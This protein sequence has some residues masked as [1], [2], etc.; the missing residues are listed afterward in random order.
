MLAVTLGTFMV[1]GVLPSAEI[2]LYV[3]VQIFG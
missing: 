1:K 2:L 3:S